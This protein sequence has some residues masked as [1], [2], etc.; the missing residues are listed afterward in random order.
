MHYLD[1]LLKQVEKTHK[2]LGNA[3]AFAVLCV[4]ARECL[5]IVA[6]SGTGKSTVVNFVTNNHYACIKRNSITRA[7]LSHFQKDL[8]DFTGMVAVDDMGSGDTDYSANATLATL[9]ILCHEH[10][11]AK[12]TADMKLQVSNFQGSILLNTQPVILGHIC[13]NRDWEAVIQDKVIRY[14]HLFRPVKPIIEGIGLELDWGIDVDLVKSDI[15][16]GKMYQRLYEIGVI[17]WSDA[18]SIEHVGNLLRASAALDR[19]REVTQADF[20]LLAKLMQPLKVEKYCFEKYGFEYG[21]VFRQDLFTLMVE[22][23]SWESLTIKRIA[24]DY[25]MSE[26]SVYNLLKQMPQAFITAGFKPKTLAPHP[27]LVKIL[28]E[29]GV[30]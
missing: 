14:Y 6:P 4:K 22:F 26:S 1:G 15:P 3:C 30:K 25:K 13:A 7:G 8:T 12:D 11:V 24:Q 9:A 19:R 10:G 18:R 23:A 29:V 28:K 27:D 21:R 20:K 16:R 17:Q 5:L 2:G